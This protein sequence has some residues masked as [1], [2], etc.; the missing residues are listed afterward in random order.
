MAFS[1]ER[2][3]TNDETASKKP[4]ETTVSSAYLTGK[5]EEKLRNIQTKA[6]NDNL[7]IPKASNDNEE[8]EKPFSFSMSG[9]VEV[10]Y[11]K[12]RLEELRAALAAHVEQQSAVEENVKLEEIA[13]VATEMEIVKAPENLPT[14]ETRALPITEKIELK[15]RND[16]DGIVVNRLPKIKEGLQVAKLMEVNNLK[17]TLEV[18]RRNA[19]LFY[20]D[21]KA[22]QKAIAEVVLQD[23]SGLS[24][25]KQRFAVNDFNAEA[26][27][28]A[29]AVARQAEKMAVKVSELQDSISDIH[30]LAPRAFKS[31]SEIRDLTAS[32]K[33][34]LP[35]QYKGG[36]GSNF[37]NLF[38]L[39]EN[40]L[41]CKSLTSALDEKM[42]LCKKAEVAN[43]NNQPMVRAA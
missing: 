2:L 32:F 8:I 36:V 38:S 33:V 29:G 21:M 43:D 28:S 24:A 18:G 15:P 23:P 3:I 12:S 39:Q 27:K 37:T 31:L 7:K 14:A 1:L 25:Q 35:P 17:T 19:E 42:K 9:K 11:A 20:A 6:A 40:N 22:M 13:P 26:D 41:G 16:L 30:E 5:V 34:E 10:P 4:A